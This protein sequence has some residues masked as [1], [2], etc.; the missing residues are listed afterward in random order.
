M[1]YF[2]KIHVPNFLSVLRILIGLVIPLLLVPLEKGFIIGAWQFWTALALFI[3]GAL[4]DF[5]DGWFARQ[6]HVESS[7]GRI[8]DPTADK[9]FILGCMASFSARGIYSYWFLVPIFLRELAVTFCRI[10]WLHQGKAIGAEVA[11]K[12]KLILQVASVSFSFICLAQPSA[13][14]VLMNYV[15]L[16]LVLLMTIYSGGAF[17]IRN[18]KLLSDNHFLRTVAAL[19]VGYLKPVPGTF[20]TLL[21][22]AVLPLIAHDFFL[23][24]LILLS[25]TVT[26][27]IVISRLQLDPHE[28][29]HEIVIDEFCGILVAFLMIPITWKTLL[30]G[31][32]LFRFFDVSKLF[33][34]N[35]LE[36][37]EGANGIM[38][39]DIGAGVYTWLA[40]KIVF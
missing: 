24:A 20:G 11:G 9:I 27:Y 10:S 31:F 6:H 5:W 7:L 17:F 19:G 25:F 13:K 12:L 21:G 3:F 15:I 35:W 28:D 33:P 36:N 39:D 22:L 4:T 2:P 40:L 30:T 29:P 16:F 26:G 23:H 38:L 32:I 18:K 8:L 14:N 37:K 34:L 1:N